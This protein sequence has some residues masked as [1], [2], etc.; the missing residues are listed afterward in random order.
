MVAP[1]RSSYARFMQTRPWIRPLGLAALVLVVVACARPVAG[2]VDREAPQRP[3]GT[4]AP[5]PPASALP[6]ETASAVSLAATATATPTAPALPVDAP[7]P[8]V[9]ASSLPDPKSISG[10]VQSREGGPDW[11]NRPEA[12]VVSFDVEPW[13]AEIARWRV[14]LQQ[15]DGQR[16]ELRIQAPKTVPPPFVPG[17]RVSAT[18]RGALGGPSSHHFVLVL[19]ADGTPLLAINVAPHQW[20]VERGRGERVQAM[21]GYSERSYG[22]RF[23]PPG[24]KAIDVRA[25]MWA[26][27]DVA[28]CGYLLWGN[29]GERTLDPKALPPRDLV[30]GW[31]D[32]AIVRG[33]VA[34]GA[35]RHAGSRVGQGE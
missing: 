31:V 32:F 20:Q 7:L 19:A 17:Q 4:G 8:C 14:T 16:H 6:A 12:T 1:R 10:Y 3:V 15:A 26:R 34:E 13:E 29:A 30:G 27:A 28:G 23:V 25:G 2:T 18:V 11:P 22:V 24:A 35:E 5:V 21:G 33:A 9:P